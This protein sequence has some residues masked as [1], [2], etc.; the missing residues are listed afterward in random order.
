MKIGC[1]ISIDI[2]LIYNEIIA[3]MTIVR[4]KISFSLTKE[5]PISKHLS[6]IINAYFALFP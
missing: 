2:I 3:K 6:S 5:N 1:D 4:R